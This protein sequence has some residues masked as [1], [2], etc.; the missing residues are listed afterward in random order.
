MSYLYDITGSV[1]VNLLDSDEDVIGEVIVN[2]DE[3][4]FVDEVSGGDIY[5]AYQPE[6]SLK[7]ILRED[8]GQ[9]SISSLK[10]EIFEGCDDIEIVDND[11]DVEVQFIEE[12]DY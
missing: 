8:E 4:E 9:V 12:D 5:K 2:A 7:F 11:L 6:F 10:Y 1:T 3:F